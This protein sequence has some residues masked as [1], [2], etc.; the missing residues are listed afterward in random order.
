MEAQSKEIIPVKL[1]CSAIF[2]EMAF[3]DAKK[4]E[5]EGFLLRPLGI[6]F[7]EAAINLAEILNS[8]RIDQVFFLGTAGS[9]LKNLEF[10]SIVSISSTMLLNLGALQELS[11]VPIQQE[12]FKLNQIK[13][14][15][16]AKCLSSLEISKDQSISTLIKEKFSST[17]EFIVENMELY[18]IAKV[19]KQHGIPLTAFL[20]V[21]NYIDANAHDDWLRNQVTGSQN[22]AKE[23]FKYINSLHTQLSC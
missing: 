22:L 9:Y 23:F 11:Y 12:E 5:A 19:C 8:K 2:E 7:L 13:N 4:L 17:D 3:L 16:Q 14:H 1:V 10:N 21:T 18:G 6:G 15:L 20:A